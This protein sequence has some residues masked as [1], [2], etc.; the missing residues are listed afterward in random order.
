MRVALIYPLLPEFRFKQDEIKSYWPPLGLSYIASLLEKEGHEVKIIDR[1]VLLRKNKLRK[2]ETDLRTLEA[3]KKFNPEMVGFSATTPLISDVKHTTN[4]LRQNFPNLLMVLGGPHPTALPEQTL[5]ECENVDILV[6]GEGEFTMLDIANQVHLKNIRG[7]FFRRN[8]KIHFT[9]SRL[10]CPDLDKLPFPARHLLEMNFYARPSPM[11]I[12]GLFL[13]ATTIFTSRGCPYKC[14]FC[15][16]P[17]VFGKGVRFH[18]P[19]YVIKE[20]K[21]VFKKYKIDGFYF[22]DDMFLSNKERAKEI[23]EL[24][25]KEGLHKRIK[26][27][28]Q[29]RV[30]PIDKELLQLMKRSGCVQVEYGFE[31]GSKKMLNAMN[32][33]T[34]V[35][36]NYRAAKLTEEVGLRYLANIIVGYPNETEED[37]ISTINFLKSIKPGFIGFYK[38]IPLPGSNVYSDLIKGNSCFVDWDNLD[39]E[40]T[41]LNLTS[42]SKE[43][44]DKL[45]YYTRLR[46]VSHTNVLNYIKSN[47]FK[48]PFFIFYNL[49]LSYKW[50]LR[51]ILWRLRY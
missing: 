16:G 8:G 42:I 45:Y 50:L 17:L 31:S 10:P 51:R 39:N 46:I 13:R 12:R 37:F 27:C 6:F 7:I 29:I 40:N 19:S 5:T 41:D 44:F 36:Q 18:S 11:V 23:C 32:K 21:E 33:G 4:L 38:L 43:K 49:K 35:E 47:L 48:N 28:A 26:W 14:N 25:Q 22:A 24:L 20:I 30:K 2:G 1:D 15:S 3:L 34:T 9:H